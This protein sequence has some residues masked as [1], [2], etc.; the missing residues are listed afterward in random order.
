[1]KKIGWI[2]AI[3]VLIALAL[4]VFAFNY[5]ERM[6]PR[7]PESAAS[8]TGSVPARDLHEGHDD[9]PQDAPSTRAYRAA[10]ERM[11]RDMDIAF[12]GDS[13]VDF[14]RGMIAHH[15]G[16]VAMARIAL[17][18]GEDPEV[19]SLAQ[20]IIR[21]QEVEIRRMRIWLARRDR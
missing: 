6:K 7:S 3:A 13:D 21:A 4:G 17:E 15:E 10:N 14:M 1:V 2:S 18:H 9:S 12:S 16:A 19:R 11:H 5:G 8:S 20:D